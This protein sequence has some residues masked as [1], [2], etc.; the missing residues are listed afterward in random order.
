MA[1]WTRAEDVNMPRGAREECVYGYDMF[2]A[3]CEALAD[4]PESMCTGIEDC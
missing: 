4:L 3:A 2:A 1:K